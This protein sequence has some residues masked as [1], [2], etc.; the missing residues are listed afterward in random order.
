MAR[1][2]P[3]SLSSL[4]LLQNGRTRRKRVAKWAL[5]AQI[6]RNMILNQSKRIAVQ[7]NSS[8]LSQI[9]SLHAA[10]SCPIK[11]NAMYAKKSRKQ[12]Y[13]QYKRKRQGDRGRHHAHAHRY[14]RRSDPATCRL[15]LYSQSICPRVQETDCFFTP[16]SPQTPSTWNYP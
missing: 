15:R 1:V 5:S 3:A 8:Q 6:P 2:P 16:F 7:C 14:I 11:S 12:W 4:N 10:R 13:H 9:Q